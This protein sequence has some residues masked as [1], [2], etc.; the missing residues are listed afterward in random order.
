M[1]LKDSVTGDLLAF[2]DPMGYTSIFYAKY[3]SCVLIASDVWC[4]KD[5]I[6]NDANLNLEY[7]QT[8][9]FSSMKH[10]LTSEHTPFKEI[11]EVEHGFGLKISRNCD[12]D[13][14]QIWNPFE[15]QGKFSADEI[16]PTF[17]NTINALSDNN[18]DI[19]VSLSGGLY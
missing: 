19:C 7:F 12:V 11:N 2:P 13:F 3:K 8:T 16:I 9:F 17:L 4:I 14:V 15:I 10:L 6:G 5:V 18:S 1:I